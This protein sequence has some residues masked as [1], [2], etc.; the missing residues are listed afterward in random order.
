MGRLAPFL[1]DFTLTS[2]FS[3]VPQPSLFRNALLCGLLALAGGWFAARAF[4][5]QGDPVSSLVL[6]E[7]LGGRKSISQIGHDRFGNIFVV[8]DGDLLKGDGEKWRRV[9]V[10]WQGAIE[11]ALFEP[12]GR[13]YLGS[14]DGIGYVEPAGDFVSLEASLPQWARSGRHWK[15][16]EVDE[17]GRL[18]ASTR[19]HLLVLSEAEEA[20]VWDLAG[21]APRHFL[22]LGGELFLSGESGGWFRWDRERGLSLV[23]G[24]AGHR[25][26]AVCRVDEGSCLIALR[27]GGLW[28]FDG[29][30]LAPFALDDPYEYHSLTRLPDGSFAGLTARCGLR[31]FSGEGKQLYGIERLQGVGTRRFQAGHLAFDD[32]LWLGHGAGLFR[33]DLMAALSIFNHLHGV[34]EPVQQI[35][36]F[37]EQLYFVTRSG[38]HRFEESSGSIVLC[39]E[40]LVEPV[41]AR[42]EGGLLIASSRELLLF[43]GQRSRSLAVGAFHCVEAIEGDGSSALVAGENGLQVWSR[44][45]GEWAQVASC[46]AF[47]GRGI[48]SIAQ[49]PSG[50]VWVELDGG[51]VGVAVG[52]GRRPWDGRV[53]EAGA[54][55][56]PASRARPYALGEQV[57]FVSEDNKLWNYKEDVG[58]FELDSL[59]A[60]VTDD[61]FLTSF[62]V[63]IVDQDDNYWVNASVRGG[64]LALLP[65]GDYFKG[66]KTLAAGGRYHANAFHLREDGSLWLSNDDGIVLSRVSMKPPNIRTFET[67]IVGVEDIETGELLYAGE[68]GAGLVQ[69]SLPY[70]RRS[71][72]FL[73]TLHDYETP[74]LN[75]Y[76][77]FLEGY[78]Q[79][80]SVFSRNSY[81]EFTNLPFGDFTFK[82]MGVN[83]YG[84]AGEIASIS[85]SIERPWYRR[86]EAYFAYSLVLAAFALGGHYARSRSLRVSN[87]ALTRMV[88]DKTMEV[89]RQALD[90]AQKNEELEAALDESVR[91]KGKAEAADRAKSE[92]LANMSHEIRTPMNG[93]LGMCTMLAD[94]ELDDEQES[95]LSTVRHSGESLLTIINDILDYSKIEAGKLDIEKVTFDLGECIEEVLE[96]L[97]HSPDRKGLNMYCDLDP[98]LNVKRVGDSTRIRQIVVNLVGNALKFTERGEIVVSAREDKDSE[99]HRVRIEVS[100]TGIGIPR[101]KL[102]RLFTAFSQVDASITRKFGGTGLGLSICRSLVRMMGGDITVRSETGKGS[103]FSFTLDVPADPKALEREQPSHLYLRGKRVLIVDNHRTPQGILHRLAEQHGL[104]VGVANDARSALQLLRKETESF[105][106]VWLSSQ[107]A[108]MD[109]CR[110]LETLR[111][112]S[113]LGSLPVLVVAAPGQFELMTR[114]RKFERCECLLNPSRRH[115]LLRSS[116]MLCGYAPRGKRRRPQDEAV[117]LGLGTSDGFAALRILLVDD[118]TV[119]LKVARHL[120]GKMGLKADTASDGLQALDAYARVR[121]DVILM[122]AQMPEMDGLEATRRIRR[123]SVHAEQPYIIAMTAGATE[124]DR[125]RCMEAGMDGFVAKPI[126]LSSLKTALEKALAAR[127]GV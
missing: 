64:S 11:Q 89:S 101:E 25:I 73:Y 126:K 91:L 75:Q 3:A 116:A 86:I 63:M 66:L 28:R 50:M 46:E 113:R 99:G 5:G 12:S 119:N 69:L 85:L 105:D 117:D 121:Y 84:D 81:K 111:G 72:R 44:R 6:S 110:F 123:G 52:M 24:L 78:Q 124:I 51:G 49:L 56:L 37:D 57:V 4:D 108:D 55:G 15:P 79:D 27:G 33:V 82:V 60:L 29:R 42:V 23:E 67:K 106:I 2:A 92:F 95:Y 90:L 36:E 93:I 31:V 32:S 125:E 118:N 74:G 19:G 13:I 21:L 122:D 17:R 9:E 114:L 7:A 94:T 41:A 112:E 80:W 65:A 97:A 104:D 83:D 120:L 53:F 40:S 47:E 70:S 88:E 96:L 14:R 98:G 39:S 1:V 54:E 48:A 30:E 61:V 38:L 8:A 22:R 16:W 43:D 59:R 35:L 34:N 115:H 87:V 77:V 71:L 127:S 109:A 76:Q 107:L 26:E 10:P 18:W 58:R 20:E 102:D 45:S 68:G 62:K 103:V 100:D